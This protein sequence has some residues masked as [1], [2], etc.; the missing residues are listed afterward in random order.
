MENKNTLL[1]LLLVTIVWVFFTIFL[2]GQ[3]QKLDTDTL[4]PAA[5]NQ[6]QV[7]ER[8]DSAGT[9]QD[10]FIQTAFDMA[11]NSVAN[12]E[13]QTVTIET[14]LSKYVFSS[15]GGCLSHAVLKKYYASAADDSDYVDLNTAGKAYISL[16]SGWDDRQLN[17]KIYKQEPFAKGLQKGHEVVCVAALDDILIEKRYVI[18]DDMYRVD[19]YLSVKNVSGSSLAIT[20]DFHLDNLFVKSED[21]SRFNFVGSVTWQ[22]DSLQKDELNSQ[23]KVSYSSYAWSGYTD[24]YFTFLVKPQDRGGL[25]IEKKEERESTLFSGNSQSLLSQGVIQ[26]AYTWY[27]GPRDVDSLRQVDEQFVNVIDFGFFSILSKPL[28]KTLKFFNVYI[29]NY[30]FSIILLTILIKL[31]FWPLTQ[32]SYTSMKAMQK[33]QP[34]MQKVRERYRN[35]REKLNQEMMSLYKTHRVNPMGGCLPM[36]VQIPVFIALY[37]VL[38]DSIELRHAPFMLWITDLSVKDPYYITP[39]VMGVTMFVQQ[40]LTPSTMDPTQAK[41]FMLMPVIF[42]FLFMNFPAGLVIYWLVNNLLTILQQ[43]LIYKKQ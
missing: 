18:Y 19:L 17:Y 35:D 2:P 31:L 40:R 24:K 20:P 33:L 14:A 28:L 10:A 36:L 22:E 5:E 38:L 15:R 34:E 32:K 7:E 29:K 41:V 26:Q 43:Y 27:V 30:G 16:V 1:A 11:D 12:D 6:V 9:N 42:T 3:K 4:P 8:G 13:E 25:T 21:S 37:K 39:V 23:E